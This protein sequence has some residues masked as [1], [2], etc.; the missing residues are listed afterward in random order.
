MPARWSAPRIR[1][2]ESRITAKHPS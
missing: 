1:T 2:T